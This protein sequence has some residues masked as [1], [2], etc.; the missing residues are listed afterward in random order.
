MVTRSLVDCSVGPLSFLSVLST[1]IQIKESGKSKS[2]MVLQLIIRSCLFGIKRRQ[3]NFGSKFPFQID[4]SEVPHV[5][6]TE[7]TDVLEVGVVPAG[8]EP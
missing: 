8:I 3:L 1:F 4:I 6:L 2:N 5:W 7:M